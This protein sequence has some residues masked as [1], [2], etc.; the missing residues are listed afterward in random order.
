MEIHALILDEVRRLAAK[1][2]QANDKID[3]LKEYV[4]EHK[5]ET[6]EKLAKHSNEI[7]EI[8]FKSGLW[9]TVGGVLSTAGLTLLK[10]IT[11]D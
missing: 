11:K 5:I 1:I 3:E 9:G 6:T 10:S 7:N 2:D 8:K 4:H